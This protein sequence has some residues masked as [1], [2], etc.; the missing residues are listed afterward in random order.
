LKLFTS[1]VQFLLLYE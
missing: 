1:F